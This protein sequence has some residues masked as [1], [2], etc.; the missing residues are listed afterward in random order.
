MTGKVDRIGQVLNFCLAYVALSRATRMETLQVLNFD[1]SKYV[2]LS[3]FSVRPADTSRYVFA[4][5]GSKH[6]SESSSGCRSTCQKCMR[7]P[8][9]LKMTSTKSSSI[10]ETCF[11]QELPNTL[12]C[13]LF[14]ALQA[15]VVHSYC[16]HT[17]PF[18]LISLI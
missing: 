15:A 9:L 18:S 4:S 8:L 12:G 11:S 10:G 1:P 3:L 5:Q 2:R 7:F 14:V 6:I 16:T 17:V 13:F